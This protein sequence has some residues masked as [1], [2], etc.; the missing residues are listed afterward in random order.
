LAI[1]EDITE[2]YWNKQVGEDRIVGAR[3][4]LNGTLLS[5]TEKRSLRFCDDNP[6]L[7]IVSLIFDKVKDRVFSPDS[8]IPPSTVSGFYV[9]PIFY[10]IGGRNSK[11]FWEFLVLQRSI[12]DS[13][14]Q[15]TYSRVGL[16]TMYTFSL[17]QLSILGKLPRKRL[18]LV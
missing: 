8:P 12:S 18:T 2:S 16:L 9:V 17:P 15:E 13:P 3:L 6:R 10:S 7:E 11:A 1:V 4:N 14:D 5:V